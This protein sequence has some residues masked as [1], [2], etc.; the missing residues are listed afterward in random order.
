MDRGRTSIVLRV[1]LLRGRLD[2]REIGA[3]TA[4][5][6]VTSRD[7][8]RPAMSEDPNRHDEPE[9]RSTGDHE[10]NTTTDVPAEGSE[11][12]ER[13]AGASP[14]SGAGTTL[15]DAEG[16]TV[17]DHEGNT[18]GVVDEVEDGTLYVQPDPGL[19]DRISASLGWADRDDDDRPVDADLVDEVT[20]DRVVLEHSEDVATDEDAAADTDVSGTGEGTSGR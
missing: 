9:S 18:V 11:R 8:E 3:A 2:R 7:H 14:G 13:G 6:S 10:A 20:D 12:G 1:P 4:W 15:D 17:V 19:T 5:H 16:K